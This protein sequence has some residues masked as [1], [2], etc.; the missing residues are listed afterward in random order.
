MFSRQECPGTD[1][2]LQEL[3]G[4]VFQM[5]I[6]IKVLPVLGHPVSQHR[7]HP[8][9]RRRARDGHLPLRSFAE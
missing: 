4:Q 9:G 5:M 8:H 6:A 2:I 3:N 1:D 7:Q